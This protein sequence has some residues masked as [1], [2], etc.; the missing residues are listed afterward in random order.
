MPKV[1]IT[2][3]GCITACGNGVGPFWR[4]VKSGRSAVG[5][6]QLPRQLNHKIKISAQ[7]K[8]EILNDLPDRQQLRKY[9]PFTQFALI[10]ADEAIANAGLERRE[11]AG[12]RTAVIIGSGVGGQVSQEEAFLTVYAEPPGRLD[13]M[14]ISRIMMSAPPS[15]IS[16]KYGATGP[17]F[18]VSSACSSA[19]QAIGLGAMMVRSGSVDRAIVGGTESALA[20][21]ILRAWEAMRVLTP[22]ACRPF[23]LGRNGLV[24]GEG[25]GI[26]VLENADIAR[27]RGAAPLAELLGY[28]TSADAGDMIRSDPAGGAA[29]MTLALAD[30]QIEPHQVDH[31]NAHGTGTVL[32]DIHESE[33]IRMAFGDSADRISVSST[34]PVHGH[35][36][37]ATGALELIAAIM[38]LLDGCAPPT[39]NWLEHDPKCDLDV[40]VNAARPMKIEI[41]LSNSLA[42]G[43]INASLIV[44]KTL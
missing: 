37:G 36:L 26:L 27:A 28:G 44:G 42:F 19:S 8:S 30:A 17:T 31:I 18:A 38:S 23:S 2:G 35:A 14:T 15:V 39:L 12:M 6:T 33:A 7:V 25:A 10:A 32:N 21:G 20:P 16:M 4:A 13:P 9:D 1:A 22:D 34:K 5:P 3:M 11:L 29:A 43:G 40:V 41:A 24:L